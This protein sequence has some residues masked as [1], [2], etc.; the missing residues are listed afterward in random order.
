M[1]ADGARSR[2]NKAKIVNSRFIKTLPEKPGDYGLRW[3]FG[4]NLVARKVLCLQCQSLGINALI[5]QLFLGDF[6]GLSRTVPRRQ[7]AVLTM[8]FLFMRL[9]LAMLLSST[10]KAL[11]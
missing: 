8:V 5:L 10:A 9:I 6:W 7:L 1:A 4:L 2:A 11:G 3:E